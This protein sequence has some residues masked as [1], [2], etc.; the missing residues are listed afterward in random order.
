MLIK[1]RGDDQKRSNLL[2]NMTPMKKTRSLV[3]E[4]VFV[5]DCG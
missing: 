4:R 5:F 2:E 3:Q 1:I